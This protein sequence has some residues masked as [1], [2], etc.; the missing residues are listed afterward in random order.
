MEMWH[1]AWVLVG[2]RLA[3]EGSSAAM[4]AELGM[5]P[6]PW[7]N[8]ALHSSES[9]HAQPPLVEDLAITLSEAES[10][11]PQLP[12]VALCRRTPQQHRNG[13]RGH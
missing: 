1:R 12:L 3:T 2:A 8:N 5:V 4:V 6:A 13:G 11:L 9:N 10:V 7:C